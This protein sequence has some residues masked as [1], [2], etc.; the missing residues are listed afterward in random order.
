MS[1][2]REVRRIIAAVT[3][4]RVS[5]CQ[6][7]NRM[8]YGIMDTADSAQMCVAEAQKLNTLLSLFP[9]Y[10]GL[11]VTGKK[12]PPRPETLQKIPQKMTVQSRPFESTIYLADL[13][14][15]EIKELERGIIKLKEGARFTVIEPKN[16]QNETTHESE[17][18]Y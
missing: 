12:V 13:N 10:T 4:H 8:G 3:K 16:I 7:I 11:D 17:A 6:S 15:V 9:I 2:L 5:I 1:H 18:Q 14:D